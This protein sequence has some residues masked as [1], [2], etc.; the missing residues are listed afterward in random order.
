MASG[1][2]IELFQWNILPAL[3]TQSSME[4][5]YYGQIVYN[6]K[7]EGETIFVLAIS[8]ALMDPLPRHSRIRY[9]FILVSAFSLACIFLFFFFLIFFFLCFHLFLS[10]FCDFLERIAWAQEMLIVNF[11]LFDWRALLVISTVCEENCC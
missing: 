2:F 1:S 8:R 11:H 9:N 3:K 6:Y 4:R 5:G 7:E 10:C